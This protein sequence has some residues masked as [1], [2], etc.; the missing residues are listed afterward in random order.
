MEISEQQAADYE[1]QYTSKQTQLMQELS[2]YSEALKY[3][4]VEG[5]LCPKKS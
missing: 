3:Y 4:Q 1:R 2:K 5:N